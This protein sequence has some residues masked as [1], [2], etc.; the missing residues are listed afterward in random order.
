[1][2]YQLLIVED[3][4]AAREA[5]VAMLADVLTSLDV[6]A[7]LVEAGGGF[8]ALKLLPHHR[9][10][11]ILTDLLMQDI[12]GFEL[13]NFIK[14]S[15]RYRETPLVIVTSEGREATRQKALEV[16][17]SGFLAKPVTAELLEALVRRYLNL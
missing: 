5:L 4:K 17:A 15:P 12:N 1:M 10:D 2:R 14:R 3:S 7:E 6:E 16:G 13:I 8:E 9:F 11:L